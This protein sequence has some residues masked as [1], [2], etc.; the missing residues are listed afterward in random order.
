[1]KWNDGLFP[2][3]RQHGEARQCD[4]RAPVGWLQPFARRSAPKCWKIALKMGVL[5]ANLKKWRFAVFL[6]AKP[7]VL[8]QNSG[9]GL[10]VTQAR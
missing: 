2:V 7:S 9:L 8:L 1:M 6:A 10:K 5:S 4:G 3:A